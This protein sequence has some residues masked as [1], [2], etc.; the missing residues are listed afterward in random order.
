MTGD[1]KINKWM[2]TL[3]VMTGSIMSSIDTSIVNVALPHMRGSF[4]ASVEEIAWVPIGYMLS[5]VVVMPIVAMMSSRFG[6][7]RYY[8]FSVLLFIVSSMLCGMAWDLTSMVAFRMLQGIGGG[9]LIPMAQAILRETFPLEEQGTAM[10]IYGI[11]AVFGPAVGPTLGGWLTDNYSWPWIF[12][13]NVPVGIVNMLLVMH[14]ISDPPYL[15]REKGKI[16][17]PGLLFL[18]IGLGALQVMLEKGE[19][20]SWFESDFILYLALT[21]GL[22]LLFFIW[23]ELA[24]D[25]PAVNLRILRN[26]TFASGTMLNGVLGMG[27]FA[28]LFLLPLLLQ[29]LLGYPA[30]DSGI[31]L[32]PR[33]IAM[34]ITML[35]AGRFYNSVGP[36]VLVGSGLIVTIFSFWK[37]SR[38]SLSIGF[39]DILIPQFLQGIGFGLVFLALSTA[40]L[41]VIE[42]PKLIAATGLYNVVRQVCG[43]IGVAMAAFQLTRAEGIARAVLVEKVTDCRDIISGCWSQVLSDTVIW[44]GS[45]PTTAGQQT[46]KLMDGEIMKQASM[47]AFNHVFLLVASV[48]LFS[49]PLVYFLKGASPRPQPHTN[50]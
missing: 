28:G 48:F 41:S 13:I 35:V 14:F 15:V 36:R 49:I 6:R 26:L 29:Q 23:R 43:S 5:L 11:G 16:D 39:Q 7:K 42:K 33:S 27:L 30:Y 45:D 24:T 8:Q 25:K 17:I 37:L 19:Q 18:I 1:D 21:A 9:T 31:A 38:L 10:G 32:S 12:Y 2:I 4:G 22:A 3:T 20:K 46:L 34:G 44:Q 40:A 47:L 50:T